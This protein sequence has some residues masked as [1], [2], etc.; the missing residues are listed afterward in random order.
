MPNRKRSEACAELLRKGEFVNC[1][2]VLGIEK[3]PEHYD[4]NISNTTINLQ[5]TSP[6]VSQTFIRVKTQDPL[7]SSKMVFFTTHGQFKEI[8]AGYKR[9]FYCEYSLSTP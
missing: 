1:L 8:P 9:D 4:T 6:E 3:E 5:V 7:D 2:Q